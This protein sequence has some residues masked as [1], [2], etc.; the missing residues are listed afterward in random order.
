[1]G[2]TICALGLL[3]TAPAASMGHII[4]TYSI[5]GGESEILFDYMF[6]CIGKHG[7]PRNTGALEEL[8]LCY[9]V[10]M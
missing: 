9:T 1:M 3:F 2:S 7:Y 5:L 6:K 10:T 8:T 4:A